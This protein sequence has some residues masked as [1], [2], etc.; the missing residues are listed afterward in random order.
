MKAEP[1]REQMK[2]FS[3]NSFGAIVQE[4]GKEEPFKDAKNFV[5]FAP[6]QTPV[7]YIEF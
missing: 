1:T 7:Q 3:K 5:N 6:E 4:Y 2:R